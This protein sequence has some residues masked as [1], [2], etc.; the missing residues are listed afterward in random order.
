MELVALARR[1]T[2][3]TLNSPWALDKMRKAQ[4]TILVRGAIVNPELLSEG[5]LE[6]TSVR[7]IAF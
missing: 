6:R 1:N 7:S 3:L 5:I 4:I 2:L